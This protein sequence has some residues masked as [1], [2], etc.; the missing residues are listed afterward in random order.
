MNLKGLFSARKTDAVASYRQNRVSTKIG[1]SLANYYNEGK[2]L[3]KEN[4]SNSER[5]EEEKE[6]YHAERT[7]KA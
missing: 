5:I 7:D 3:K 1:K 4:K 2:S 6:K